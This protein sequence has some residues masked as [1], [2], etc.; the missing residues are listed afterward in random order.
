M[1]NSPG[2]CEKFVIRQG[3]AGAEF[4]SDTVA[5]HRAPFVM[6]PFQPDFEQVFKLAVVRDVRRGNMAV[7]IE[8]RFVLGVFMLKLAGSL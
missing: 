4:F 6:I 5:A 7:I 8:N 1:R 3:V 2:P